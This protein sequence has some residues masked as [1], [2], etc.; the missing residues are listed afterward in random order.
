MEP[1]QGRGLNIQLK[2]NRMVGCE[3]QMAGTSLCLIQ[4]ISKLG[5]TFMSYKKRGNNRKKTVKS[6]WIMHEYNF[7]SP[8]Y[9]NM[10]SL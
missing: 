8:I 2:G 4:R 10:G 1:R 5:L 3:R 9:S 6:G 7:D